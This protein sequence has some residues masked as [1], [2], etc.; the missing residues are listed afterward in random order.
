MFYNIMQ[1]LLEITLSDWT[2]TNSN[3]FYKSLKLFL[4]EGKIVMTQSIAVFLVLVQIFYFVL[5][6]KISIILLQM[7]S[8]S[9]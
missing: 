6:P 3:P 8:R 1:V 9:A 5:S 4:N 7:A 2:P